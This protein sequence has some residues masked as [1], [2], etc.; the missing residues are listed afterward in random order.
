MQLG[1]RAPGARVADWFERAAA[2]ASMLCLAHCA[3]LP[4]LLAALPALSK[5]IA[6]PATFHLWVLGFAVPASGPALAVGWR[7]HRVRYPLA[8]GGA[9]LALLAVGA[10]LLLGGPYETP[11]TI[12]GSLSLAFAHCRQLAASPCAARSWLRSRERRRVGSETWRRWPFDDRGD[13]WPRVELVD[14]V[15]RRRPVF[16]S[17]VFRALLRPDTRH[18]NCPVFPRAQLRYIQS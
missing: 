8:V 14:A 11:A 18:R 17:Q 16:Q 10:L 15:R 4:L 13:R 3:G 9:G 12:A 1:Q 5:L 7:Q 2:G 6:L